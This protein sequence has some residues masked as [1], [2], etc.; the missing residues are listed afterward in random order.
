M[1]GL[2]RLK[3]SFMQRF[4]VTV[5]TIVLSTTVAL[6]QAAATPAARKPAVGKTAKA[7]APLVE[8]EM[9]TWPEVKQALADGKTTALFYTGGTEQRGPQNANGGH[10]FLAQAPGK[11]TRPKMGKAPAMPRVPYTTNN[12][13]AQ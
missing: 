9:M 7:K 2:G 4:L 3:E 11:N 6:A 10:N 1:P 12:T 8:F 5:A 13:S